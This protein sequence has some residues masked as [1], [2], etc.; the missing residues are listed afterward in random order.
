MNIT[1]RVSTLA[2]STLQ[3]SLGP[4]YPSQIAWTVLRAVVGVMMIHNGLDKLAD[5]P[6]FANAYVAIIGLPFPIFFSYCA[7][8]AE[9][10]GSVL[11][12]LGLLS[13]PAAAALFGTMAVAIYHHSLVAGF[14][15]PYLELSSVYAATFLFFAVNG[16]GLFSVDAWLAGALNASLRDRQDDA[17]EA[18]N[19]A[20]EQETASVG[21]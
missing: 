16:G 21:S 20:A 5:I 14:N 3:P 19:V 18:A 12:I 10:G 4:S 15:L 11:L 13:R 17:T 9:L 7:A 2:V 8:F 1:Q 6:G